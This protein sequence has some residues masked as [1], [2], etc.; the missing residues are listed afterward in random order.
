MNNN[1]LTE[2][3]LYGSLLN[4]R[5]SL[6]GA[7][8]LPAHLAAGA[9]EFEELLNAFV[10]AF[11]PV[12]SR[13][14]GNIEKYGLHVTGV[15]PTAGSAPEACEWF[16]YTTG[17]SRRVGFELAVATLPFKVSG[18][19]LNHAATVLT[20]VPCEGDLIDGVLGGG[21]TVRM[22]RCADTSRFTMTR[23]FYGSDPEHGVWQIVLP[24]AAGRFPDEPGYNHDGLPQ[25]LY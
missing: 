10:L 16:S 8:A 18:P 2:A 21:F 6:S 4:G 1:R 19:I 15:F 20:S 23:R 12:L 11:D 3:A 13:V 24:D 14:H 25:P 17:L 7:V 9:A 5:L 22:H